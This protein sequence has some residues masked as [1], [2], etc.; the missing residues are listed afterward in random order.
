M[1]RDGAAEFPWPNR[2]AISLTCTSLLG[3]WL[4]VWKMG[5]ILTILATIA[6]S[7]LSQVTFYPTSSRFPFPHCFPLLPSFLL[8]TSK[9]STYLC[10]S[11]FLLISSLLS[12]FQLRSY[13]F[14]FFIFFFFLFS[15]IL[16]LS[17]SF[18][19]LFSSL[20][21]HSQRGCCW[22]FHTTVHI[23]SEGA[24][25]LIYNRYLHP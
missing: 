19:F 23:C 11:H 3:A 21:L 12:C 20:S 25:G 10:A 18:F 8:S 1:N 5:M 17:C 15:F 7:L 24:H 22:A 13:I 14:L 4:A 9:S 2:A 16:S 6:I